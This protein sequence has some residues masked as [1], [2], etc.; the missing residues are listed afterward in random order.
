MDIFVTFEMY[1]FKSP[2]FVQ[3]VT[4]VHTDKKSEGVTEINGKLY[5]GY[6]IELIQKIE[7]RYMK[8]HNTKFN[9]KMHLVGDN[10]FGSVNETT[11]TW[12]GM[13]GEIVRNVRHLS[14]T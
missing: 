4:S 14:E 7:E 5:E 9:F 13:I 10:Q 11:R 8:E 2:P 12:N 1:F 6:C 3:A